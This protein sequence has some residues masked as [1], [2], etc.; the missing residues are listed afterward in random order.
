MVGNYYTLQIVA[1]WHLDQRESAIT[2]REIRD[3][4]ALAKQQ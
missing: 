3:C 1:I 4:G 2:L